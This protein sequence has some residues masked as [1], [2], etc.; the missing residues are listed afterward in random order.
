[1]QALGIGADIF[2]HMFVGDRNDEAVETALV[3]FG[4]QRVETGF[5]GLHQHGR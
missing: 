4:A 5:M 3:E 1:M 2:T